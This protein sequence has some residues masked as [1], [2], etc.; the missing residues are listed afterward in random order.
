MNSKLAEFLE[1]HPNDARAILHEGD[2]RVAR[3]PGRSQGARPH[4]PQVRA[5]QHG[6]AGQARRLLDHRPGAVRDVPRRGRLAPAARAVQARD[7]EFQAILPLRGKIINVE[8]AP[9]QQGP[10]EPE[11]QAMITA[12]GTGIGEEFDLAQAALPQDRRDDGCGR[13]RRAHPHADPDV[14]LPPHARADRA[15]YVY[16]AQPPLYRIKIG[17]RRALREER[18]RAREAPARRASSRRSRSPIATGPSTASPRSRY[19]RFAGGVARVRRLGGAPARRVRRASRRLRQGPP[20][21]RGADPTLDES[22]RTSAPACP[23]TRRTASRSS[24]ATTTPRIRRCCS[25]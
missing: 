16:I 3:P 1:E 14:L 12:I 9:H 4:A 11:I 20:P 15:G 22:V 23:E 7:R 18:R 5:R 6:A 19:A 13:R 10:L 17:K 2:R 25:R 24:R 8:K 21:D